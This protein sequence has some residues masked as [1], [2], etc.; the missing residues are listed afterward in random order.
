VQ[1]AGP[2]VHD[3]RQTGN[4]RISPHEKNPLKSL[5]GSHKIACGADRGT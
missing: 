3:G 5:D 4:F 1:I 2:K